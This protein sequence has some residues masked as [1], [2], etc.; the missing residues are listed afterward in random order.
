MRRCW[1]VTPNSSAAWHIPLSRFGFLLFIRVL[2]AVD[3][4]FFSA[5]VSTV[6]IATV[7]FVLVYTAYFNLMQAK[8]K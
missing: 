5:R 2:F 1:R 6:L 8:I 4:L 3:G 7:T